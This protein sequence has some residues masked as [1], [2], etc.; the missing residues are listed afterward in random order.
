MPHAT[1][2]SKR[3]YR[4]TINHT[5]L[6]ASFTPKQDRIA[7]SA[8]GEL[9]LRLSAMILGVERRTRCIGEF[10]AGFTLQQP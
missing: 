2:D 6:C 5:P 1:T 4:A 8:T 10:L 3:N 7:F 9:R